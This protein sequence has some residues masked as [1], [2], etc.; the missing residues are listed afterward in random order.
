M[1]FLDYFR[2]KPKKTAE[3]AKGRLQ[4]IIAQ[5]RAE[6][7]GPDLLN[8]MHDDLLAVVR[9]YVDVDPSA[10]K[11]QMD[12]SG[13]CKVLEVNIVLPEGRERRELRTEPAKAKSSV[14]S[15]P[16][17]TKSKAGRRR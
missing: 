1:S 11:V 4:L 6:C 2:S 3:L 7:G 14:K 16:P 17:K 5:E 8:L 15:T 9:K 13:G 12:K 10:V